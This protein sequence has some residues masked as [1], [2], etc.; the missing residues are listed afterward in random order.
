MAVEQRAAD[1]TKFLVYRGYWKKFGGA[2]VQVTGH[3]LT[4]TESILNIHIKVN[5]NRPK[6]SF[7]E[8][9]GICKTNTKLFGIS[10]TMTF[11]M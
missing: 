1:V 3:C 11:D 2:K 8:C 4:N 5:L 7:H 10:K 6:V 9:F